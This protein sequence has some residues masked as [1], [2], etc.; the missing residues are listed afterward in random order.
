MAIQASKFN[1]LFAPELSNSDGCSIL[2]Q[3]YACG[4]CSSVCPVEKVVPEFDPRKVIHMVVLGL[5]E[6]LLKSDTIWACSQCQSCI[7]VCPQG[8]RCSDVIKALR[9]EATSQGFID[10]ERAARLGLFAVV[11]PEKCVACLTCVRLCPFGAPH[12]D[13]IGHA[14]IEPE[15]CRACGLCVLECPA[16]AIS[17]A[18]S[19]EQRGLNDLNQQMNKSS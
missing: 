2:S 8:V 15:L 13:E 12:I 19:I 1:P 3:C 17:L 10:A 6:E 11:D 18:P 14:K 4:S 9:E 5:E 16:R 7:P